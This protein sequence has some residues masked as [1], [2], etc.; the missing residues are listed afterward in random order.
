VLQLASASA[1][2]RILAHVL[3]YE[4]LGITLAGWIVAS[5]AVAYGI[6]RVIAMNRKTPH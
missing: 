1:R 3:W 6:G 2:R 4:I 5:F